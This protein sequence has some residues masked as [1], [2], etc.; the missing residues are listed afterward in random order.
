MFGPT[1]SI[2]KVEK[3]LENDYAKTSSKCTTL[4][5]FFFFW[6]VIK[7]LLSLALGI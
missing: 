2:R 6:I 5:F 7:I 1:L 4:I 3:V